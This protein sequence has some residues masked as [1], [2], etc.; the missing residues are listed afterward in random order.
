MLF[1]SYLGLETNPSRVILGL[2]KH[3]AREDLPAIERAI[4]FPPEYKQAGI[5]ILSYFSEV[6]AKK[7]PN[8]DIRVSI[9]QA[10]N[11]VTLRIETMAGDIEEIE[12]TLEDY[13]LV[14][15]GRLPVEEFTEDRELIRDLKMKLEVA[16]LELRLRREAYL[17]QRQSYEKRVAALEDQ[18][19]NLHALVSAGLTHSTA[20][21]ALIEKV[22]STQP[23]SQNLKQSL[24]VIARLSKSDHSV[25][26]EQEMAKA[27]RTVKDEGPSVYERLLQSWEAIPANTA[28][29]VATP[30]VINLLNSL[31][32]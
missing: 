8:E 31:P 2:L 3:S 22:S 18:V 14:V 24:Q 7:Y 6:L 27:L 26:R 30:W 28:A 9:L 11:K 16:N 10:G 29:N 13:G 19:N 23:L 25:D 12:R 17:E 1:R 21:A 4:E 15:S 5:G 32:R 20:L